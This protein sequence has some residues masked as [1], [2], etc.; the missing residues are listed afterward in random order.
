MG[1]LP[2]ALCLFPPNTGV[3]VLGLT[4]IKYSGG[5]GLWWDQRVDFTL[6]VI[7]GRLGPNPQE[8]EGTPRAPKELLKG[9]LPLAQF[10]D[11]APSSSKL[12]ITTGLLIS[13]PYPL[14][15]TLHG[16]LWHLNTWIRK[17]QF[18]CTST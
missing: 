5:A 13:L 4:G 17:R 12:V 7:R 11:T 10:L 6:Q 3:F 18:R 2:C 8:I 1:T 16:G 9:R 15:P 14:V